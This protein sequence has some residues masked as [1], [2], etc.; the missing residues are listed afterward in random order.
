L[1]SPARP[2]ETI[3]MNVLAWFT[4]AIGLVTFAGAGHLTAIA[5][6][7]S[8]G[9]GGPSGHDVAAR[10]RPAACPLPTGRVPSGSGSTAGG[11]LGQVVSVAVPP[12]AF[13]DTDARGR[14]VSATTNT[15]CPPRPTDDLWYRAP[16]GTITEAKPSALRGSPHWYP[17]P[18]LADTYVRH[19]ARP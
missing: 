11:A 16:D 1:E 14:V 9:A 3:G 4:A 18:G 5:T 15:G 19:P 7:H 8:W 6:G 12:T 10:H 17:A 2:D 13:I